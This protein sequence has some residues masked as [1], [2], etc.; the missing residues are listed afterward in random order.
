MNTYSPQ[1]VSLDTLRSTPV[2]KPEKRRYKQSNNGQQRSNNLDVSSQS[3][4]IKQEQHQHSSGKAV[5][6]EKK[7]A[8]DLVRGPRP[9]VRN[10]YS[11][12]ELQLI[13]LLDFYHRSCPRNKDRR[14]SGK[15]LTDKSYCTAAVC[16]NNVI[17][18]G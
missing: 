8:G 18:P 11:L 16:V 10:N 12:P 7:E 3:R 5:A 1:I 15:A 4:N 6:K 17:N 13:T 9:P 2:L 14:S